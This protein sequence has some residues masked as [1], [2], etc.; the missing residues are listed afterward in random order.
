[1]YKE[2]ERI[3]I[4]CVKVYKMDKLIDT[5]V[6]QN[7]GQYEFWVSKMSIPW[8]LRQKTQKDYINKIKIYELFLNT[9]ELKLL[10]TY[11]F[12]D[13]QFKLKENEY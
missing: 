4:F 10:S 3:S 5:K 9:G 13:G 8:H 6:F 11:I 7:F 1:M 2:F 12:K